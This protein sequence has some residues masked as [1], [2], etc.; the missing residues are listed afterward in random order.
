[1]AVHD[2]TLVVPP[3]PDEID[4]MVTTC[5]K[6]YSLDINETTCNGVMT[7]IYSFPAEM[8]NYHG[9]KLEVV[10]THNK[11]S[12][13]IC[14]KLFESCARSI[15]HKFPEAEEKTRERK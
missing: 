12:V 15:R 6:G 4:R 1:M 3:I 8:G 5:L 10:I 13:P 2:A 7:K 11:V 9:Q 14:T